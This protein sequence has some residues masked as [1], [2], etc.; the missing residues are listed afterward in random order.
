MNIYLE[1]SSFTVDTFKATTFFHHVV[2]VQIYPWYTVKS[3][4][5]ALVL[6]H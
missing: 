1:A 2:V 3:K 5:A 4:N 6:G